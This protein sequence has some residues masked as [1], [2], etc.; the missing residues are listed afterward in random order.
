MQVRVNLGLP[1]IL[2]QLNLNVNM[3]T[4]NFEHCKLKLCSDPSRQSE[5]DSASLEIQCDNSTQEFKIIDRQ[6]QIKLNLK[7]KIKFCTVLLD[8]LNKLDSCCQ[9]QDENIQR[10]GRNVQKLEYY[11]NIALLK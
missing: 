7:E 4:T 6:T 2:S 11:M 9:N 3:S 5:S 10:L 1:K 8:H